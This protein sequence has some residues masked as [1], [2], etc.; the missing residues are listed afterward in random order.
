MAWDR[1]DIYTRIWGEGVIYITGAKGLI[2]KD[3]GRGRGEGRGYQTVMA[4]QAV[5]GLVHLGGRVFD[6]MTCIQQTEGVGWGGEGVIRALVCVIRRLDEGNDR[7]C[8]NISV[9]TDGLPS[10]RI[11]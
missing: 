10:S 3:L 6:A 11:T 8:S 7:I 2:Y 1:G 5:H 9:L 4:V